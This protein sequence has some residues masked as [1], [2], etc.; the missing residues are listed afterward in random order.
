MPLRPDK[1]G[2]LARS[3]KYRE[4]QKASKKTSQ[5]QCG[6]IAI[7][8]SVRGAAKELQP[9]ALAATRGRRSGFAARPRGRGQRARPGSGRGFCHPEAG[10]QLAK[11]VKRHHIDGD[12]QKEAA[13]A[14]RS[15]P[16]AVPLAVAKVEHHIKRADQRIFQFNSP[17]IAV[18][19]TQG[20]SAAGAQGELARQ[21]QRSHG[22]KSQNRGQEGH[23][24]RQR[25]R[26]R[27]EPPAGA[28]R[29]PHESGGN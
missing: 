6:I 19:L 25:Q 17:P 7:N 22:E 9:V 11:I 18:A 10:A 15:K 2:R 3:K 20:P 14:P 5:H 27:Q 26:Q 28:E 21:S 12:R 24:Q 1:N 29:Q 13:A 23:R 4:Q 8:G 16:V